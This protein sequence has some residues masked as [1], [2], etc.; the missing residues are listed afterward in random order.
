MA[1]SEIMAIMPSDAM[2]R[3]VFFHD[4]RT[5]IFVAPVPH[6]LLVHVSPGAMTA[7]DRFCLQNLHVRILRSSPESIHP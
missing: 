5:T 3:E 2:R 4:V 6:N 7:I 1:P